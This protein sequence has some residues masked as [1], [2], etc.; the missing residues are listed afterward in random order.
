L[1]VTLGRVGTI[2]P[3][4]ARKLAKAKLGAVAHG[5]DPAAVKTAERGALTLKELADV[6]ISE[7]VEAKRK[8]AT[9][10]HYRDILQRIVLPE[11]GTRQGEK[12]TTSD[13]ARLHVRMKKRPYQ[14]NRLLAVVGSLYAF[15]GKRKLVPGGFN[16]VRGIDKYPEKGRERFLSGQELAR[17]GGAI[18]EGETIGIPWQVDTTKPT[19]KHAPGSA[20]SS[21]CDGRTLI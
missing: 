20:K 10:S 15:A 13:F 18:R 21:I 14:A 19:A 3:D 17:L 9:A 12:V 8:P 7:H 11:F 2:T 5:L 16:P 1:F 4:E 6:F